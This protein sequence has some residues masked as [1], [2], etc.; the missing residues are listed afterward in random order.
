[1]S[2]AGTTEAPGLGASFHTDYRGLDYRSSPTNQEHM[3]LEAKWE[4]LTKVN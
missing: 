4:I 2:G 3:F 1:V